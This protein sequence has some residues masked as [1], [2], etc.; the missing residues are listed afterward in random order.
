MN[1][2]DY[3]NRILFY[4]IQLLLYGGQ[5][6]EHFEWDDALVKWFLAK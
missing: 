2:Y 4:F 5:T 6:H 1:I 3:Y